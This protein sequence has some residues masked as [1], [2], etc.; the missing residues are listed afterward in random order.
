ME[1]EFEI[2]GRKFKVNKINVFKQ[3]HIV[4]KIAPILSD[5]LPA[6]QDAAKS[7]K[8]FEGLAEEEKFQKLIP[9]L[10]PVIMGLSK[11]S[12]EESEKVFRGLL[13][14]VD[15]KQAQGWVKIAN[16]TVLMFDDLELPVLIQLAGRAFM[17]NLSGFFAVLPQVS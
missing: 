3:F 6:L 7:Q 9:V 13:C 5:L 2:G 16:D 4:R 14:A 17:F 10:T 15:L 1:R 8:Q 12:D 11:M